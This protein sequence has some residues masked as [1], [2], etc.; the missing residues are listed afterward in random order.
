[1]VNNCANPACNKPLHY[2]R[3]GRVFVFEVASAQLGADGKRLRHIEHYWLCGD[4]EPLLVLEYRAEHG[5][6]VRSRK[7]VTKPAR[8]SPTALVS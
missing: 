8:F 2:L 7:V 5:I 1:M 4:C 3:D 6:S